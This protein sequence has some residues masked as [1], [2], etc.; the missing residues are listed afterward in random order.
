MNAKGILSAFSPRFW[1]KIIAAVMAFAITFGGVKI[2]DAIMADGVAQGA[3]SGDTSES[4]A[5]S[6]TERQS[7]F[8]VSTPRSV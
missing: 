3:A 6:E 1:S 4:G 8:R 2:Y 7:C 5:A